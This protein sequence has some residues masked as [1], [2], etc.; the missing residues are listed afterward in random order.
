MPLLSTLLSKEI[1]PNRKTPLEDETV[2]KMKQAKNTTQPSPEEPQTVKDPLSKDSICSHLATKSTTSFCPALQY[3]STQLCSVT[4]FFPWKEHGFISSAII[5]NRKCYCSTNRNQR[6]L[7]EMSPKQNIWTFPWD[8]R[9]L[10]P[11]HTGLYKFHENLLR[12]HLS[13]PCPRCWT[14]I[15]AFCLHQVSSRSSVPPFG[16]SWSC[17]RIR[18]AVEVSQ[19]LFLPQLSVQHNF[20]SHSCLDKEAMKWPPWQCALGPLEEFCHFCSVFF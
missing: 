12:M 7:L 1:I 18:W 4:E 10:H 11:A 16:V 15:R 9:Q 19:L 6:E 5:E 13:L 3:C 2:Q 20:A 8:H 17:K 14:H